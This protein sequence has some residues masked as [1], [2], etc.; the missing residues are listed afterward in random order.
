MKTEQLRRMHEGK[1][2]IA[3]LDQSGG[4]TPAALE[5]YGIGR[6]AYYDEETMYDLVHAMRTRIM[7]SPAFTS[8]F[9][10]GVIL[11]ENTMYRTVEGELTPH[12]LWKKKGIVPFL[13]VDAGL[14]ETDDGV[15]VMKTIPSLGETLEEAVKHG[16]FGTKMRSVIHAASEGAIARVVEQQFEVAETIIRAGLVPIIEPEVDITIADKEEAETILKHE[17]KKGLYRLGPADHV[18]FK[19]SLP[20]RDNLY[21]DLM[22]DSR[23]VRIV[24]LSGGYSRAEADARLARNKGVIA[25][26][27]RALVEGLHAEMPDSEFEYI[28]SRSIREIYQASVT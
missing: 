27:S 26:F 20:T 11:F 1:G 6:D 12:Y 21:Y 15:Q 22:D 7:T 19:L 14:E 9:I 3:A 24:A 16:I 28:L 13:K 25:S 5:Q 4:S 23:V 10:L 17:L 8:D 2:F 18:M